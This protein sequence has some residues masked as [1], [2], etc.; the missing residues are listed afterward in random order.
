VQLSEHFDSAEFACRCGG[1]FKDCKGELAVP[2]LVDGLEAL[3]AIAYPRG[4]VLASAYRCPGRN[5]VVGGATHSQHQYGAAADV[6]LAAELGETI[7]LGVFSGIGWQHVGRL[8]SRRKL[9]RHV[10]VR[11]A[12]GRNLTGGTVAKPTLWQYP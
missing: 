5:A 12:S 9:V 4:L 6:A 3:R 7:N 2:A 8:G 10:D 11:H 1:R